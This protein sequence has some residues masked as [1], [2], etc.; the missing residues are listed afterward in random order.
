MENWNLHIAKTVVLSAFFANFDVKI[1]QTQ[2]RE[3]TNAACGVDHRHMRRRKMP[4]AA[5]PN[6]PCFAPF[7][8]L[9]ESDK[10]K[11][12]RQIA[13]HIAIRQNMQTLNV[14]DMFAAVEHYSRVI[15]VELI[16]LTVPFGMPNGVA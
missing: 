8:A 4:H 2:R 10:K 12:E 13:R 11:A 7:F 1:H 14:A 9:S 15:S 5:L 16:A 6:S 3:K